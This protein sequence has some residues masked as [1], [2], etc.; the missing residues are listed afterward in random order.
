MA[1]NTILLIDYEPRSIERFRD[2]LIAAGFSVE[3][4][5]DGISGIEAF[6][7]LNP[8]MVLVEAMIPKKHGFEVCQELKKTPHGRVTPVIITTG[9]Y[10]GRKYRTQALHIYGCDEYIEKPIAP[11]QLLEVVGK[12]LTLNA[13]AT[14]AG[15]AE[16]APITSAAGDRPSVRHNIDSVANS[17][18][19]VAKDDCED[20]ITARL[21]ALLSGIAGDSELFSTPKKVVGASAVA[22][23]PFAIMRAELDAELDSISTPLP[24]ETAPK[25]EPISERLVS[26]Q[27]VAPSV[28]EALSST[29]AKP[30]IASSPAP[31]PKVPASEDEEAGQLVNFETKRRRK[32]KKAEKQH[33]KRPLQSDPIAEVPEVARVSDVAETT[34]VVDVVDI[35]DVVDVAEVAQITRINQVVKIANA[36]SAHRA[37]EATLPQ[38]TMVESELNPTPAKRGMPVWAWAAVAAI[39]LLGLY[40]VIPHGNSSPERPAPSPPPPETSAAIEPPVASPPEA[41]SAPSETLPRD[42]EPAPAAPAASP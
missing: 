3:I 25:L 13:S 18:P 19:S 1:N 20:E 38:G 5:T 33:S 12:F 41:P 17:G 6:H 10:K 8:D 27:M 26:D 28:L 29:A 30:N 36:A 2:P 15:G 21:D 16:S 7:R 9:V 4:A 23:D 37:V 24:F 22:L 35:V 40:F 14:S 32:G 34:D 42:P 39:T 31:T 11:A